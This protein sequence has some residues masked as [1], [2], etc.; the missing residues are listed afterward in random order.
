[1]SDILQLLEDVL[2]YLDEDR[3]RPVAGDELALRVLDQLVALRQREKNSAA[4]RAFQAAQSSE[5]DRSPCPACGA[6]DCA[7]FEF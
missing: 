1:M 7:C 4:I 6:R 5:F 2:G 3:H